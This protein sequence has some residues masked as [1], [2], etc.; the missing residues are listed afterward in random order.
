MNVS[1]LPGFA[2]HIVGQRINGQKALG[3]GGRL[4]QLF[5][6]VVKRLGKAYVDGSGGHGVTLPCMCITPH[7]PLHK[8]RGQGVSSPTVPPPP[9]SRLGPILV[10]LH[11]VLL[12]RILIF[13]V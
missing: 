3:P 4:G 13:I 5:D 1:N 8:A 2:L 12:K 6:L 11:L 9:N 10:P 7:Y